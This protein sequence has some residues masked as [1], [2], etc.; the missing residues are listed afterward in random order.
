M[1]N[2]YFFSVGKKPASPISLRSINA[3]PVEC[4]GREQSFVLYETH[5]EEV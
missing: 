2:N 1:L 3:Y 4:S 5:T